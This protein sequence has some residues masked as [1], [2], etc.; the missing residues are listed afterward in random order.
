MS[1]QS[2]GDS[3]PGAVNALLEESRDLHRDAMVVADRALEDLVELGRDRPD[4]CE[5]GGDPPG[6]SPVRTGLTFGGGVL[7]AA[8]VVAALEVSGPGRRSRWPPPSSPWRRNM[9]RSCT[10]C[11]GS[12]RSR[13]PSAPGWV[14]G[15]C[16]TTAASLCLPRERQCGRHPRIRVTGL[17]GDGRSTPA[18][19]VDHVSGS[20]WR[21][22]RARATSSLSTV[23]W[24]SSHVRVC[25]DTGSP[26]PWPSILHGRS[27]RSGH[28]TQAIDTRPSNPH[29][30]L[31]RPH[32][33]D[34]VEIP[35]GQGAE[36][37]DRDGVHCRS[38]AL[39]RFRGSGPR[40]RDPGQRRARA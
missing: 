9:P 25:S 29:E 18:G 7:A 40:R 23:L 24:A 30:V 8:G 17:S 19:A 38:L 34:A 3:D 16:R 37:V 22:S 32:D 1:D 2:K 21:R 13:S 15:R 36:V 14:P 12:T 33:V 6:R 20:S 26:S 28:Q 4:A 39:G 11:S 35:H 27:A 31:R 10:S 5:V